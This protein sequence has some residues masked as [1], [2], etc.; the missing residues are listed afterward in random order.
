MTLKAKYLD[1]DIEIFDNENKFYGVATQ[2]NVCVMGNSHSSIEKA[3]EDIQL[4]VQ[5]IW[6]V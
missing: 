5:R 6:H 3:L 1:W 4:M 2:E